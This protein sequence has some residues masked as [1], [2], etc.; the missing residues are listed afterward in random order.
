MDFSIDGLNDLNKVAVD[1]STAGGRVGA[2]TALVVRKT[3]ADIERDGKA[4]AP[5]DTGNLRNSIS[6]NVIGDGRSATIEA[7]IGPTANYGAFVEYGT[8]RQAPAAYMGPALDRHSGEFVDA[9]AKL[10]GD[11]L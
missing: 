1:L 2:G 6:T 3:A 5:V 11:L 8:T 10:T 9:L 4:F 7:E